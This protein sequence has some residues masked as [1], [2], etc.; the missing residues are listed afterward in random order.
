MPLFIIC[1]KTLA[2]ALRGSILNG[3][4]LSKKEVFGIESI[5]EGI[6]LAK[7]LKITKPNSKILLLLNHSEKEQW[8]SLL[9]DSLGIVYKFVKSFVEALKAIKDIQ[10]G[11]KI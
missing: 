4:T 11:S 3:Q 5:S 8:S 6:S 7:S 2:M 1:S 9:E 10:T